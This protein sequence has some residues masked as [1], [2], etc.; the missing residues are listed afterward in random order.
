M[1]ACGRIRRLV[2]GKTCCSLSCFLNPRPQN[3]SSHMILLK[4]LQNSQSCCSNTSPY[5]VSKGR[6]KWSC[7]ADC[8]QA[9][10]YLLFRLNWSDEPLPLCQKTDNVPRI[11]RSPVGGGLSPNTED[12]TKSA[13]VM[14]FVGHYSID[15]AHVAV[16][17]SLYP[18]LHCG[19]G[20]RVEPYLKEAR[21]PLTESTRMT[22]RLAAASL[23]SLNN[24]V[25]VGFI[26]FVG[27][28]TCM[29]MWTYPALLHST[30]RLRSDTVI[31]TRRRP[32]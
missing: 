17:R 6:Q 19:N 11:S 12:L 32:R 20:G 3:N 4:T 29:C 26:D 28:A 2:S 18:S 30:A 27:D 9:D 21:R 1:K 24:H 16:D 25:L 23:A 14:S 13:T 8:L 10:T 31:R 7:T 5:I 22:P 15:A